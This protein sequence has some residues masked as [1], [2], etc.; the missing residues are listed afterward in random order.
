MTS[1]QSEGLQFILDLSNN[2]S[3]SEKEETSVE[4]VERDNKILLKHG[5]YVTDV[6]PQNDSE[7]YAQILEI[8]ESLRNSYNDKN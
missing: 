8:V 1:K 2:L 6:I 4:I 5:N 7:N 3:E